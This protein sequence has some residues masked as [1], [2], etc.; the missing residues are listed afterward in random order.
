MLFFSFGDKSNQIYKKKVS[1]LVED[2]EVDKY[3]KNEQHRCQDTK[4]AISEKE[5]KE[6]NGGWE[7]GS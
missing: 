2:T 3:M 6:L 4:E 5:V 7:W 1:H